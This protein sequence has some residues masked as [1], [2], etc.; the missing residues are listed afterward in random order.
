MRNA[1][2]DVAIYFNNILPETGE[3]VTHLKQKI[4]SVSKIRNEVIVGTYLRRSIP[5]AKELRLSRL[6]LSLRMS[7]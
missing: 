5:V 1:S 4:Y 3:Y 6:A 2:G 7:F